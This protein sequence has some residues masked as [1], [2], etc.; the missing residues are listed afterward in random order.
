A[1]GCSSISWGT[2]GTTPDRRRGVRESETTSAPR[3]RS[4]PATAPPTWPLAPTTST[5]TV[6]HCMARPANML[7]GRFDPTC[8]PGPLIHALIHVELVPVADGDT[9]SH[10]RQIPGWPPPIMRAGRP[11]L[12]AGP[13]PEPVY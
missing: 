4:S 7:R 10:D 13:G 5:L 8:F 11:T 2:S 9:A 12:D 6:A 3:F 1:V